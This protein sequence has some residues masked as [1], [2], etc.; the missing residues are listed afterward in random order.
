MA[1]LRRPL[2]DHVVII[3]AGRLRFAGPLA[4]PQLAAAGALALYAVVAIATTVR[5]EVT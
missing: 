1:W 5:R 4:V 3:N 2:R